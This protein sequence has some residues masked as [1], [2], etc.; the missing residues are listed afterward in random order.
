MID[1]TSIATI[2]TAVLAIISTLLGAKYS[3]GKDFAVSKATALTKLLNDVIVA[4][5][6][7]KVDETEFQQI[8]DDVKEL[9]SKEVVTAK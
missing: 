3:Q 4:A 6:D 2:I 9:T 7:D 5:K 8:V 1:Y